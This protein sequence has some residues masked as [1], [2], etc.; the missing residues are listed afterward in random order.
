MSASIAMAISSSPMTTLLAPCFLR[1]S[2][3]SGECERATIGRL[4]LSARALRH[5]LAALEGVG[6][7]NQKA[8]RARQVGGAEDVGVGGVAVDHLEAGLARQHGG[9][10]VPR[11]PAA[12]IFCWPSA[13][14]TKLP[15]LP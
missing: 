10:P 6:D 9:G 15:T 7:R 12:G 3:S 4:G 8:A 14:A 11:S 2:V 1:C 13:S 5:D